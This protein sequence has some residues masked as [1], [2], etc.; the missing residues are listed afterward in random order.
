MYIYLILFKVGKY[1]GNK[2][3]FNNEKKLWILINLIG[4]VR[5]KG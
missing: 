4:E 3:V 5:F 2:F 1:K